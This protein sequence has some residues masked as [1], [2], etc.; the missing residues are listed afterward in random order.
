MLACAQFLETSAVAKLVLLL[1]QALA[2]TITVLTVGQNLFDN[3]DILNHSAY[4]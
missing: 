2:Y 1:G 3:A 4:E